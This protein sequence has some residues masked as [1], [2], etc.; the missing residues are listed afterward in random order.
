MFK[1]LFKNKERS[2]VQMGNIKEITGNEFQQEVINSDKP[3]LVDF[4]APWCGPCNMVAKTLDELAA[5]YGDKL[6]I[7]KVNVDENNELA[8]SY[9]VMSIPTLKVFKNGEEVENIMGA[10]PKHAIASQV[11]NHL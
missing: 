1:K 5:D 4:W 11:D 2:D 3:V 6:K 7:V 9:E 8:E 10:Q